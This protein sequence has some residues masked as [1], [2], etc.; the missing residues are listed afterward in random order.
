MRVI[1]SRSDAKAPWYTGFSG[2]LLVL[3]LQ[4]HSYGFAQAVHEQALSYTRAQAFA[5]KTAYDQYCASCHG[6]TL[7]GLALAP[8]L[9]GERFA[10][11]WAGKSVEV[12]YSHMRRMPL[13]PVAD[14]GSLADETYTS[15]L[16]YVLQ[17]NDIGA[18]SDDATLPFDTN[19]LVDFIIPPIQG[20]QAAATGSVSDTLRESELLR[21]LPIVTDEMLNDPS[22]D[23]WLIWRRTYDSKGFSPLKQINKHNVANLKLA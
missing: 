15:I 1:R 8:S 5:G 9:T 22:P 11:Q 10:V 18:D 2:T 19:S 6:P 23:D 16:A 12:L 4:W 20:K 7:N 17:H 13:Q 21:D 3:I 14:P